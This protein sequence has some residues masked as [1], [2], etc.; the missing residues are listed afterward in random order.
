M[1][2]SSVFFSL[3]V[4]LGCAFLLFTGC[5]VDGA[6]LAEGL[7]ART[8]LDDPPEVF[9]IEDLTL[10]IEG[11]PVY[12]NLATGQEVPVTGFWDFGVEYQWGEAALK[13]SGLVFFY[14]RSGVSA[15]GTGGVWF[16]NKT[17]FEDVEFDDR[18]TDFT[19]IYAEYAPYVTD[20]NRYAYGMGGEVYDTP[21]NMMTYFGFPGGDG[22]TEETAFTV[23]PFVPPIETYKFYD[24]DKKAAYT[25]TGGMP[26]NLAP[27]N[28][29]Y[30]IQH[31]RGAVY[32]KLQ[33]T[34]FALNPVDLSYTMT[35]QFTEVAPESSVQK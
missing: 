1:K 26:P 21:M 20:V 5:P 19:G 11:D 15:L 35:I 32:S 7:G 14:T 31:G 4:L 30:I 27:T 12:Y 10:E 33:V 22:L 17:D 23:N 9:I 28:Q 34:E 6:D 16:T 29:V 3:L 18:V 25:D 8:A 13:G 24:F 2:Q